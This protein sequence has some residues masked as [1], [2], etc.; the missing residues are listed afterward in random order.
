MEQ[1]SKSKKT[2]QMVSIKLNDDQQMFAE[3]LF[4]AY[5]ETYNLLSPIACSINSY[6]RSAEKIR[7]DLRKQKQVLKDI[8]THVAKVTGVAFPD[9]MLPSWL[10]T[11][12]LHSA[13]TNR[14]SM[15]EEIFR[16]IQEE[17][18]ADYKMT[19]HE[20]A[21]VMYVAKSPKVFKKIL[22]KRMFEV[23]KK[24][25][26]KEING[27]L[28]QCDPKRL[29]KL[30][31]HAARRY[32]QYLH[33]V[34]TNK[35]TW[36]KIDKNGYGIQHKNGTTFISMHSLGS[37]KEFKVEL[38]GIFYTAKTGKT[39]SN[40]T[41]VYD[42]DRKCLVFQRMVEVRNRPNQSETKV[43][44]DAGIT[45]LLS[46]SHNMAS[47]SLKEEKLAKKEKELKEKKSKAAQTL[48]HTTFKQF[49]YS[50][51]D[52]LSQRGIQRNRIRDR[53]K[54]ALKEADQIQFLL[55]DPQSKCS[56]D[57][58]KK[59]EDQ[60]YALRRKAK[61]IEENNRR[62]N[63]RFRRQSQRIQDH[64]KTITNEEIALVLKA[65]SDI[66]HIIMENLDIRGQASTWSTLNRRLSGW[67]Y[68]LLQERVEYKAGLK[69]I[70]T[71]YVNQAYSSQYCHI[72]GSKIQR[73]KSH[74]ENARC[75]LHGQFNADINAAH[76]L[77][78][79]YE[80]HPEVTKWTP[81]KT[82]QQFY[83]KRSECYNQTVCS[84]IASLKGLSSAKSA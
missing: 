71:S 80:N 29:H 59:L 8:T 21:V 56:E 55:N 82:V 34:H 39:R 78:W 30:I 20:A 68:G 67:I 79:M 52:F 50:A 45:S 17:L 51:S 46:T 3:N 83:E 23:P 75:K 42:R 40:L 15:D 13:V 14:K 22:Q 28:Q 5:M 53:R 7:D 25:S 27:H 41:V 38:K 44:M 58:K 2:I 9:G 48:D 84:L 49:S 24:F 26:N 10:W 57:E 1:M 62:G 77:V 37:Q 33:P 18:Y 36:M 64:L 73:D 54:N 43:G 65:D 81:R 32:R 6:G 47:A 60:I 66:G 35:N 74:Y 61:R 16:R 19:T 70:K 69:S 76:N 63:K 11:M 4:T 72:C 31:A 12:A